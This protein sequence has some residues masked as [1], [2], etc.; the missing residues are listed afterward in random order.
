MATARTHREA[1]AEQRRR[2]TG[3]FP[4]L[5]GSAA[6]ALQIFP[7]Q[8]RIHSSVKQG[9]CENGC[10]L[11]FQGYKVCT[12]MWKGSKMGW[13]WGGGMV[14]RSVGNSFNL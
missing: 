13:T 10:H 7:V 9:N 5:P 4:A 3:A 14:G 6:T 1:E 12:H 8:R 2:Q 11:L